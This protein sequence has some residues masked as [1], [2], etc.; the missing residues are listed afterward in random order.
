MK[1]DFWQR[2][3]GVIFV[4]GLLAVLSCWAG[5]KGTPV[6]TTWYLAAIN[7]GIFGFYI[8]MMDERVYKLK[9]QLEKERQRQ[10]LQI[11]DPETVQL[12]DVFLKN[13]D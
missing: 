10:W 7:N 13:H 2:N 5:C 1:D 3:L 12:I 9:A 8:V 6:L 4:W 11:S